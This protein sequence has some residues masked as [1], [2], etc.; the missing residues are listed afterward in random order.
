MIPNALTR[1]Q[2]A[3]TGQTSSAGGALND[4]LGVSLRGDSLFVANGDDGNIVQIDVRTG[5]QVDVDL[6]DSSGGPPP[7][8]GA[9]FGLWAASGGVYFVDDATNT[10]NLLH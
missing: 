9:L 7:G 10:F 1:T 2:S 5:K 8:S 3:G 4:P 6:V